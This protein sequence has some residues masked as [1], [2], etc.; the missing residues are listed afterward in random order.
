[1]AILT[2][3]IWKEE[4]F[5]SLAFGQDYADYAE[6]VPRFLPRFAT[7]RDVEELTTKPAAGVV[8]TSSWIPVSFF[9]PSP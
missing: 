1:M 5:M 8:G 9:S 7:W 2:G 3:A 6:R 4:A